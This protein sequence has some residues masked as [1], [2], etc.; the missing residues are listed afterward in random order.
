MVWSCWRYC[1]ELW[2]V[3]TLDHAGDISGVVA[4]ESGLHMN[5]DFASKVWHHYLS[6]FV[7]TVYFS[8]F[9]FFFF[10]YLEHFLVAHG[11]ADGPKDGYKRILD[12][13]KQITII[14][15][16]FCFFFIIIIICTS[17]LTVWRFISAVSASA[18]VQCSAKCTL[19]V[20]KNTILFIME[21]NSHFCEGWFLARACSISC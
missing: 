19:V 17:W 20:N 6:V 16:L 12:T 9:L 11:T 3:V 14:F 10:E 13:C 18:A 7:F 8:F 2:D 5:K 4:A 15:I 21:M 1:E